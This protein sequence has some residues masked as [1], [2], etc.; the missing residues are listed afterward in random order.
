[1][2]VMYVPQNCFTN[3]KLLTCLKMCSGTQLFNLTRS[4]K[5][6]HKYFNFQ[7]I[8]HAV[9]PFLWQ[10]S[11]FSLNEKLPTIKRPSNTE[12]PLYVA[13]DSSYM[14]KLSNMFNP[15][16]LEPKLSAQCNLQKTQ[17]L[18]RYPLFCIFLTNEFGGHPVFSKSY[19]VFTIV[20]FRNQRVKRFEWYWITKDI[21]HDWVICFVSFVLA[22]TSIISWNVF[23]YFT[24]E[25]WYSS[26][27]FQPIKIR[28]QHLL[29]T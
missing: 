18:N 14:R 9:R 23:I 11:S 19:S 21:W 17:N 20:D 7:Y 15:H 5:R 6:I 10:I 4:Y 1:M 13:H 27:T 22:Q 8:C 2:E 25:V 24:W 16:P 3:P 29:E 26:W 28:A 12:S